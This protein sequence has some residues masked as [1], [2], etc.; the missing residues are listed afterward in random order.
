MSAAQQL[1]ET[2]NDLIA[3]SVAQRDLVLW[4]AY[5]LSKQPSIDPVKLRADV[6]LQADSLEQKKPLDSAH[7]E[8]LTMFEALLRL[9]ALRRDPSL[10]I[11]QLPREL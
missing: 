8:Q 6:F 3:Q 4:L 11:G 1:A 7:R 2:I 9:G 5:A 10:E